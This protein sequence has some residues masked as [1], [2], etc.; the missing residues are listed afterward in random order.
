MKKV[1][2]IAGSDTSGGAGIQADL[3]TFQELGVYG[4]SA[5]T[6]IVTMDPD[7]W[8]HQVFP[9]EPALVEAQ[10]ATVIEG[11]GVD[12]MKTGMLPTGE[13]IELVA[14]QIKTHS[15]EKVV[16]DPVMVCKGAGEPVNP[17]NTVCYR[18]ALVPLA[19]VVTP[20]LFEASQLSGVEA[21]ETIDDMK[22]AAGIICESGVEVVVVK[23]GK[24]IDAHNAVDVMYDGTTFEI[25]ESERI[26]TPN[27]HGAGC[28]F[29]AA[30][31][32][33]LAHGDT[34]PEAVR[35]AK[36]FVTEAIRHSFRLN[37]YVGPLNHGR[38]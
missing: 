35:T 36:T 11:I 12:A 4:M 37:Q 23:G 14:R 2:T 26:D 30:I 32:A 5:L 22:E 24:G 13:L 9:V 25:L 16:V 18:D 17:G 27:T 1:L 21:I 3:K 34:I 8:S 28:T 31:A 38:V 20:N 7:G 10:L 29:A 15:L 33:R 6:V 19:T